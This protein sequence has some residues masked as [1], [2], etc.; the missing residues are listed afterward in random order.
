M[1]TVSVEVNS[2]LPQTP[3][4]LQSQALVDV[5]VAPVFVALV[6]ICVLVILF[7]WRSKRRRRRPSSEPGACYCLK[8]NLVDVA[9]IYYSKTDEKQNDNLMKT[10]SEN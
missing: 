3:P 8:Y 2:T 5:I 7:V 10:V 9:D 6:L 1:F 4:L